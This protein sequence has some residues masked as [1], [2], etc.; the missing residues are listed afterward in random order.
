MPRAVYR[1][2]AVFEPKLSDSEA[3]EA[4]ARIGAA[5]DV[6]QLEGAVTVSPG[7]RPE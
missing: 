7:W 3:Q 4:V 1:L 6:K 5:L 2:Y